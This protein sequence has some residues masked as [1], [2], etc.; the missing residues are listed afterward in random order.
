YLEEQSR[1]VALA[2]RVVEVELLQHLAHVGAETGDVVAQV[3]GEVRRVGQELREVVTRG[4]VEREASDLAKLR[5]EV[6]ELPVPQFSLLRE[7]LLLGA[8]KHA[9]E[10]AQNGERE[11]DV[12]VLAPLES[13]PDQVRDAPEE[14]DDL[15]M[16]HRVRALC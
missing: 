13:V 14:A 9:V 6:L 4:V 2:D 12:L 10:T 7:H 16:V 15:A 5:V 11:D 8:G 3:C 1:L